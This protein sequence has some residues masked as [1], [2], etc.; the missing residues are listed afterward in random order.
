M[1]GSQSEMTGYAEKVENILHKKER[2][3]EQKHTQEQHSW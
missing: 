1:S 3:K 2:I